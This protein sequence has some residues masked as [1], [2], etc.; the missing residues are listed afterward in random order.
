MYCTAKR[1]QR[2][3]AGGV[4]P[5]QVISSCWIATD[6]AARGLDI[7]GMDLVINFDMPRKGDDYVHRAGRTGRQVGLVISP[8]PRRNGI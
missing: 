2:Q 7:E 3:K 4:A 1:S 5:Q 6:V 8:S